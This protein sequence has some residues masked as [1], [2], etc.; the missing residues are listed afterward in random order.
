MVEHLSPY[1]YSSTGIINAGYR[2]HHILMNFTCNTAAS[3]EPH[4]ESVGGIGHAEAKFSPL[5]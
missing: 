1:L 5:N 3:I 2:G 4:R